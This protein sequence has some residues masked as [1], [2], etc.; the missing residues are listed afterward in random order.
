MKTYLVTGA[1]GFI[2]ANY[3]KYIL[4]KHNDI[5]A[6]PTIS[7][8]ILIVYQLSPEDIPISTIFAITNGINNSNIDS[9]AAHSTP[10][11]KGVLYF[12]IYGSN[13]LII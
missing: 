11:I 9:S 3:I 12:F 6:I 7:N 13:F 8:P 2:G 5:K 10:K 4:A 1:A